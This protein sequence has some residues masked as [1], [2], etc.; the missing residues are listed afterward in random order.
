MGIGICMGDAIIGNIGSPHYMNYTIIGDPVKTAARLIQL[1]KPG[2]VLVC[3]RVYEEV[4]SVVHD[5]QVESR[6][7]VT[8]R[9]RS[10]PIPVYSVKACLPL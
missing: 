4:S 3:G 5:E 7:N 2:E 6:G 1:A 9:G 8:L 10:E